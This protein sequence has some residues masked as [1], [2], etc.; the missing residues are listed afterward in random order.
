M[1][2]SIA[3]ACSATTSQNLH[4][5]PVAL[6]QESQENMLGV[7]LRVLVVLQDFVGTHGGFLRLFGKSVKPHFV[8]TPLS[9]PVFRARL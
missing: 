1:P 4:D 5:R 9:L 3:V 6:L 7:D 8:Y 2:I